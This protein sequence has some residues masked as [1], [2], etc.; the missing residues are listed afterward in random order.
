MFLKKRFFFVGETIRFENREKVH[1]HTIM[2][3]PIDSPASAAKPI[4]LVE[5][6]K[7][8]FFTY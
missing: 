8:D 5:S 6:G 1:N 7:F 3:A 4:A 2:V